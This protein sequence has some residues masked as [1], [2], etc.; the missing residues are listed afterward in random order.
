MDSFFSD[1]CGNKNRIVVA[2]KNVCYDRKHRDTSISR[3]ETETRKI[4]CWMY[5]CLVLAA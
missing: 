3:K 1:S 4:E 2:E 5:A